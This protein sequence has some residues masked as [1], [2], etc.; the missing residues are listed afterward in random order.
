MTMPK[1]ADH[2]LNRQACI[3]LRQSTP[4]QVR[5]NQESTE[6]QYQLGTKAS[7]F[8]WSPDRI[9]VLDRDL[10][11]SGKDIT[12]R[13]DFKTLV[14]DVAMGTVGAVFAMEASR[15]ARSNQQWHRLLEL[16][17]ITQHSRDR[18]GWYLRSGRFQRLPRSRHE[19]HLRPGGTPHHPRAPPW[20]QAQQG[21]QGGTAF[22]PAGRPRV[23]GRQDR[24]RPRPGGPGGGAQ[25]LRAVRAGGHS[26][27]AWFGAS[28][29]SAYAFRGAHM[30][31]PGMAA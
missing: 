8:G 17:A 11:Q 10:G 6:R 24:A 18:R 9:R 5:F 14:N 12:N 30:A 3:Y 1:I 27:R 16:C 31:E 4:G 29:I 13:D 28:R 7:G 15:L 25:R 2:H 21:G 19:R 20:R 22:L 26:L 23:R